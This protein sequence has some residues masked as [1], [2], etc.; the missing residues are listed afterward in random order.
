[1]GADETDKSADKQEGF[2]RDDQKNHYKPVAV[3]EISC[4]TRLVLEIE[5]VRE[6]EG[7]RRS[8]HM[9]EISAVLHGKIERTRYVAY[10][11]QYVYKTWIVADNGSAF[12]V[13]EIDAKIQSGNG[14]FHKRV[15]NASSLVKQEEV[16]ENDKAFKEASLVATAKKGNATATIEVKLS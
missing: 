9:V 14:N 11:A 2:K 12:T 13:D 7:G 10:A 1:M 6:E 15:R 16:C 8:S 5:E 3:T 4:S